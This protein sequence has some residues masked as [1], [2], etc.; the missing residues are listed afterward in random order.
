M[1][2]EKFQKN[3]H[4]RGLYVS[5]I[6]SW[7]QLLFR[8]EYFVHCFFYFSSS[9]ILEISWQY[10][11]EKSNKIYV[12]HIN[13]Y[14]TSWN[15]LCL[16]IHPQME[17]SMFQKEAAKGTRSAPAAASKK[18]GTNVDDDFPIVSV[19]VLTIP[20]FPGLPCLCICSILFIHFMHVLQRF[21]QI[22]SVKYYRHLA[23]PIDRFV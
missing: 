12:K 15:P 7:V 5:M 19:S 22:F 11:N 8:F 6:R 14:L 21:P 16:E 3:G 10:V 13:P 17:D 9:E 20:I 1:L 2:F 18:A 4:T 23:G